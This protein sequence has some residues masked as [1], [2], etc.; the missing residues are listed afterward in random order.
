MAQHI[1]DS[2]VRCIAM[3]TTD[4]LMRGQ[5]GVYKG[6]PITV[7]VGKE[8]LGRVLNVIGEPVDDMGAVKTKDSTRFTVLHLHS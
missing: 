6:T 1:G 8:V 3:E 2:T 5:E 7:P 4:G